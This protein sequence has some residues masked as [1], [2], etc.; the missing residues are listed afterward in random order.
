MAHE[1][2]TREKQKQDVANLGLHEATVSFSDI[3]R[4]P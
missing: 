1:Q 4:L 3:E 2:N